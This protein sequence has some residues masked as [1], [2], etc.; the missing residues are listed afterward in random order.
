[1][2]ARVIPVYV[3]DREARSRRR[4]G[5]RHRFEVR[6]IADGREVRVGGEPIETDTSIECLVV[7][8]T[9]LA[10]RLGGTKFAGRQGRNAGSGIQRLAR[11]RFPPDAPADVVAGLFPRRIQGNRS[12]AGPSTSSAAG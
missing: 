7:L 2:L 4:R 10:E 3:T 9:G 5:G 8:G 6:V 11:L 1:M 12:R